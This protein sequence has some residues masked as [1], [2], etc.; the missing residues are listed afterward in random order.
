V[1]LQLAVVVE[2]PHDAG[3]HQVAALS[4][5][6]AFVF[7]CLG[8]CWGTFTSTG[9]LHRLTGRQAAR[10]SHLVLITLA[11]AFATVHGLA[12]VFME[13]EHFGL[14]ELAVPLRT[15]GL[16]QALGVVALELMFAIAASTMVHRLLRHHQW[17]RLHRLG[18]LAV[19][20]G[21]LHSVLGAVIDGHLATLW[22]FGLTILVPVVL[23]VALRFLPIRLLTGAGLLKVE[24]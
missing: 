3:V 19:G 6:L 16:S 20:L 1:F 8:L 21:V 4:A 15:G 2:S 17:L 23:V 22:L 13:D 10:S 7:L 9:W 18:Y 12:F 24:R 11:L 14:A 5:R